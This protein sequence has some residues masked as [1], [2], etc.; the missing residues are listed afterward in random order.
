LEQYPNPN[1]PWSYRQDDGLL[2]NNPFAWVGEGY[3][4][5]FLQVPLPYVGC[6]LE[7]PTI[8]KITGTV[9][10]YSP[11]ISIYGGVIEDGDILVVPGN[12]ANILWTA[13][14]SGR[15]DI[16]G[17]IWSADE[18]LLCYGSPT[19]SWT[20]S[21]NGNF[22]SGGGV[23]SSLCVSDNP[24]A[25]PDD[26][27]LGSGGAAA[28]QGVPVQAGDR[29][30]LAF[31]GLPVGLKLTITLTTDSVDPIAAVG[32]LATTVIQMNLQNGISN[33]LDSKLDAALNVLTDV[34]VNNDGAACNS[35]AAFINAV[36]AQRGKKI[37][38]AQVA[39]IASA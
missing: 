25:T 15:I 28:L 19:S 11:F 23:Q 37:T 1:G 26:F 6:L 18:Q 30:V 17:T 7:F 29:L 35:L 13:L 31:S 14:E 39:Q 21:R 27:S 5:C 34:N 4:G 22:L 36:E 38:N 9:K 16:S 32:D 2:V 10:A 20:L 24:R 3:A 8:E 33:S 12:G